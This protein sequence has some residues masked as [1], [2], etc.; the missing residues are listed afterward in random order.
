MMMVMFWR[1][2]GHSPSH[3]WIFS[4]QSAHLGILEGSLTL[5]GIVRVGGCGS[6]ATAY[7]LGLGLPTIPRS[8]DGHMARHQLST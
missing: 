8:L 3:Q 7:Q 4:Y 6:Y 1:G 5:Q 2:L